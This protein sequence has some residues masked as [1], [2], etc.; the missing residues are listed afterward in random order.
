MKHL[1]KPI[2]IALLVFSA[3]FGIKSIVNSEMHLRR[4]PEAQ[5]KWDQMEQ[6]KEN[7]KETV[8]GNWLFAEAKKDLGHTVRIVKDF[9]GFRK[10]GDSAYSSGLD[11]IRGESEE[12]DSAYVDEI[13]PS[14]TWTSDDAVQTN[15]SLEPGKVKEVELIYVVDGDTVVVSDN[16]TEYKVRLIGIDTPESVHQDESKNNEYGALASEHTKALLNNV[17]T[18]YIEPGQDPEDDYGRVLAYVWSAPDTT[19]ITKS[20][21]Y[22]ILQDGYADTLTIAPNDKWASDFENVKEAAKAAGKGLWQYQGY[23]DILNAA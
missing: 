10:T 22:I 7:I 11:A 3:V 1:I 18:I 20:L 4:T 16:G 17:K 19:D 9:L 14:I 6:D 8:K 21:N 13:T 15:T 5:E 23:L 2:V 12:E